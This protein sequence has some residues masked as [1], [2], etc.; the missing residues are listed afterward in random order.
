MKETA[1]PSVW[2]STTPHTIKKVPLQRPTSH[3]GAEKRA[4]KDAEE[5]KKNDI[6]RDFG[7][8]K[9]ATIDLPVGVKVIADDSQIAFMKMELETNEA[10]RIKYCLVVHPDLSYQMYWRNQRISTNEIDIHQISKSQNPKLTSYSFLKEVLYGLDGKQD[11]RSN[12][13]IICEIVQELQKVRTSNEKKMG[14]LCEQLQLLEKKPTR[15]RYS[16]DLLAFA[17]MWDNVSPDLYRQIQ[18]ADILTLTN[19]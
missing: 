16:P 12:D 19:T 4:I 8:L 1:L 5:K 11:D 6:I 18:S 13:D 2:P 9:D 3:A 7:S 14:F 10:P 17:C 15:R